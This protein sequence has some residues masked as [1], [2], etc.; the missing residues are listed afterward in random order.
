MNG[1]KRQIYRAK[2]GAVALVA[3]MTLTQACS[4]PTWKEIHVAPDNRAP[5]FTDLAFADESVGWGVAAALLWRTADGGRSWQEL[6]VPEGF[7]ARAISV[8]G[9][10]NFSV[11][12]AEAGEQGDDLRACILSTDD[13]G[14]EWR[15]HFPEVGSAVGALL[16][17]VP[18]ELWVAGGTGVERSKDMGSTWSRVLDLE[19]EPRTAACVGSAGFAVL[20]KSGRLLRTEDG[21]VTWDKAT[22]APGVPLYALAFHGERGVSVGSHGA[23]FRSS[24]GGGSWEQVR[25]PVTTGILDVIGDTNGWW[26]VGEGGVVLRGSA[27]AA[28]WVRVR[29]P[30]QLTLACLAVT[31]GVGRW[32]AGERMLLLRT[33][34]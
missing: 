28:E 9:V 27:D 12:G 15:A 5:A 11:G 7:L 19:D 3:L 31:P 6:Q 26:A 10:R 14:V 17:C 16:S 29:T 18:K 34:D 23:V 4:S 2:S 32:A 22:I 30:S 21:G 1:R 33:V 25:V 20:T 8:S 24:D 13:G